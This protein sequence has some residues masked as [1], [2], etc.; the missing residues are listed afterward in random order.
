MKA[1]IKNFTLVELLIV[2]A[3]IAILASMLL[4]ALNKAREKAKTTNCM[5]NLKQ[6]AIIT[7]NYT[8]EQYGYLYP[9]W[10]KQQVWTKAINAAGGFIG[11]PRYLSYQ[12]KILACPTRLVTMPGYSMNTSG[13]FHYGINQYL[14][15]DDTLPSPATKLDKIKNPSSRFIL[16]ETTGD[17]YVNT[18]LYGTGNYR[19]DYRHNGSLNL[20][21]VDLHVENRK[22]YLPFYKA[23]MG[24]YPS[25]SAYPW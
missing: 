17:Y 10:Y 2:I 11:T 8:L 25:P 4:P 7:A 15:G 22:A 13:Y 1:K 5:S 20:L 23:S 6:L 19:L 18:S 9:A 24:P 12:P 21:F 16:T 14:A 3:I